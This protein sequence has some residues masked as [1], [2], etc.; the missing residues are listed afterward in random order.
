MGD[1]GAHGRE[2]FTSHVQ[3][4]D[5]FDAAPDPQA[6][7][8]SKFPEVGPSIPDAGS[9]AIPLSGRLATS[10]GRCDGLCS[11]KCL[12]KGKEIQYKVDINT[13]HRLEDDKNIEMNDVGR[14]KI[15]TT[16]PLF[17]DKYSRNRNTGSLILIDEA[18]NE[19]VGAGMII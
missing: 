2:I 13:L 10:A 17:F 5:G 19:T 9:E 12:W 4:S 7:R 6:A 16:A 1:S 8:H 3:R 14:I 11:R 15:R 18:T